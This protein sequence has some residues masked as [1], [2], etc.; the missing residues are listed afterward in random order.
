VEV[1]QHAAGAGE[2]DVEAAAAG[3]VAQRLGQVRLAHP[4]GALDQDV[5][6]PLDEGSGGMAA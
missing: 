6:V 1:G 3:F 4:G 2:G 5:F